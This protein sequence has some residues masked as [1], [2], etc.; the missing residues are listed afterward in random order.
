MVER[1][2]WRTPDSTRCF[3]LLYLIACVFLSNGIRNVR[4]LIQKCWSK[5][6]TVAYTVNFLK[7]ALH[8]PHIWYHCVSKLIKKC[9]SL[10]LKNRKIFSRVTQKSCSV[11][12]GGVSLLNESQDVRF[13]RFVLV[14]KTLFI[15]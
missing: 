2:D 13:H 6:N 1:L 5:Y 3:K 14:F 8:E 4:Y 12:V 7:A 9:L 11:W 15:R 10:L